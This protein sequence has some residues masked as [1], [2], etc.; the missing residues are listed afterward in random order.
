MVIIS[1]TYRGFS[2]RGFQK[3]FYLH[4]CTIFNTTVCPRISYPF[5]IVIYYIKLSLLL[6]HAVFAIAFVLLTTLCN[7]C[8]INIISFCVR[9]FLLKIRVSKFIFLLWKCTLI[10]DYQNFIKLKSTFAEQNQGLRENIHFLCTVPL[11]RD[12]DPVLA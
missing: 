3:Y 12:E 4:L 7:D 11:S 9:Q 8:Y 1:W 10:I 2:S 6:E 5:D